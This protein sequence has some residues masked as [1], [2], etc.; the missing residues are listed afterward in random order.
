MILVDEEG[1]KCRQIMGRIAWRNSVGWI[2]EGGG[3]C[4]RTLGWRRNSAGGELGLGIVRKP[5]GR[6][7]LQ[8]RR[9]RG[10]EEAG[11]KEQ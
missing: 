4:R 3:K 7:Q 8:R 10:K 1:G 2:D 6:D 11:K 9:I 5:R